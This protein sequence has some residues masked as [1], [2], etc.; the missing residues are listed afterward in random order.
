MAG[1]GLAGSELPSVF[2]ALRRWDSCYETG[3]KK[4]IGMRRAAWWA[5]GKTGDIEHVR[6]G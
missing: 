2:A 4:F 5:G 1:A 3:N 6:C